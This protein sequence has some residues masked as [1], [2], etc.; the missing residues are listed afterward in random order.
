M[1]AIWECREDTQ[2]ERVWRMWL[3][4]KTLNTKGRENEEW[5]DTCKAVAG[6]EVKVRDKGTYK[7]KNVF[8]AVFEAN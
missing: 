6:R 4:L 1:F 3:K 5:W 7:L 8:A 2:S